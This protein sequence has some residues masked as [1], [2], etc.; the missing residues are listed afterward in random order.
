[1]GY[2]KLWLIYTTRFNEIAGW[3]ELFSPRSIK[4]LSIQVLYYWIDDTKA[5]I[6]KSYRTL[7]R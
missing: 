1:M 5:V 3:S 7:A 6:G 2:G 4:R